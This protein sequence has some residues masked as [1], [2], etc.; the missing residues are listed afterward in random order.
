MVY[1]TVDLGN[2]RT[3]SEGINRCY[4]YIY[5]HVLPCIYPTRIFHVY[6]ILDFGEWRRRRRRADK[7]G[8]EALVAEAAFFI[9]YAARD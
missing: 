7:I 4:A 8:G 9:W 2:Q 1:A 6:G 3:L 5:M